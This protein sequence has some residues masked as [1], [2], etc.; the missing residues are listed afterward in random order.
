MLVSELK[1]EIKKYDN[2]E[3]ESIIVSLY[4][5]IPKK[6]KKEYDLDSYIK[7][8]NKKNEVVKKKYLLM[9]YIMKLYIL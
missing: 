9:S 5:R 6:V 1:N 7:D 4:K 2:K 3:L 8:I